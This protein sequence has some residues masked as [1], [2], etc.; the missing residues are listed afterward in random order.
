M[1]SDK[2]FKLVIDDTEYVTKVTKKFVTRKVRK[3][4]TNQGIFSFIPGTIRDVFVKP[5]SVV[6]AGDKLLVLEAM[7]MKNQIIAPQS[8][9]VKDVKVKVNQTVAKNEVMITFE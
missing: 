3:S 7:K 6:K 9:V 5:G 2:L 1:I 4:D 8:G